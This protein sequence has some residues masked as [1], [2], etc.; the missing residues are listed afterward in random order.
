MA[1]GVRP[2]KIPIVGVDKFSKTFGSIS[3]KLNSSGRKL[4]QTGQALTSKVTLP[5]AAA[6][7][8]VLATAGQFE[9]SMNKVGVLTNATGTQ[10][11]MLSDRARELGATTQ[12]SASEA[13][14]AMTFLAMAGL[15]TQEVFDALPGT[16]ELAAA[17]GTDLGT[18]ADIA[19]NI[20]TPFNMKATELTRINDALANTF[21]RTNTNMVQLA[22]GMKFVAPVASAMNVQ[23]EETAAA[24]GLLGNAGIQGAMAGTAL[25][26]VL[27]K[28]SAPSREAVGILQKLRIRKDDVLDSQ[29]NVKSLAAVI[30]AFEEAGASASDMLQIFGQRAGPGM[31]ALVNQGAEALIKQTELNKE[32]GKAAEVAEARMKGFFGQLLKLKSAAQELAISFGEA[33]LLN[34]FTRFI[35]KLTAVVGWISSL[36]DGMKNTIVIVSIVT[37]SIG[38][39]LIALGTMIQVVGFAFGG[40]SK[41]AILVKGLP[42]I[43]GALKVAILALASPFAI[44]AAAIGLVA[45]NIYLITKNWDDFVFAFSSKLAL[46][47]T[48]QFMFADLAGSA[49]KFSKAL[50]LDAIGD[51]FEQRSTAAEEAAMDLAAQRIGLQS[52]QTVNSESRVLV[53]VR[54]DGT[55]VRATKSGSKNTQLKTDTGL[56]YR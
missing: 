47:Q 55:P 37:A 5:I 46:L 11:E 3:K 31:S 39:L 29:G 56:A 40:L 13:A 34:A 12:F 9:Q 43:F 50:G 45:Y 44:S 6:G 8:A 41:L 42:A 22:E 36:D 15:E 33:G 26:G 49:A 48:L 17:A 18:A 7:V 54:S 35:E 1:F 32:S 20:M 28:I 2:I 16:L 27:A 21:T 30:G 24:I 10:F 53:E 14:S 52:N 4:A 38:P 51:F 19:T 25:R 23:M